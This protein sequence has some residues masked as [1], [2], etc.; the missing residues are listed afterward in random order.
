MVGRLEEIKTLDEVLSR[1]EGQLVVVYGRRR[2][3]K[4]YLIRQ[5]FKGKFTLLLMQSNAKVIN[6]IKQ[7]TNKKKLGE[8]VGNC[9]ELC[10]FAPKN[11]KND[12]IHRKHRCQNG[13]K[14]TC[15]RA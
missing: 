3:G 10:I 11:K 5:Y 7:N 4:T 13:R 12:E 8:I 14:G 9:G 6:N 15:L 2:I 1:K